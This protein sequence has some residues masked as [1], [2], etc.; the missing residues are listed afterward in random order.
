M[1]EKAESQVV[2][3]KEWFLSRPPEEQASYMNN[4]HGW[5]PGGFMR[6]L[7]EDLKGKVGGEKE[8]SRKR[9]ERLIA[10][11]DR[12]LAEKR[13]DPQEIKELRRVWYEQTKKAAALT[14][15]KKEVR[16]ETGSSVRLRLHEL[17]KP[18]F[19]EFIDMKYTP[20]ELTK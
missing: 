20:E 4:F 16:Q 18:V 15:L 3:P 14:V 19:L 10:D 7:V 1:A 6:K 17:L 11:F 13:I 9:G 5:A 8:E 12:I 2:F